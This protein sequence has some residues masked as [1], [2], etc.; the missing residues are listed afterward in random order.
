MLVGI[1]GSVSLLIQ[2]ASPYRINNL[3]EPKIDFT[4]PD[5]LYDSNY[6][7]LNAKQCSTTTVQCNAVLS[8]LN[9]NKVCLLN[10]S[11]LLYR[12]QHRFSISVR[13]AFA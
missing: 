2:Y 13:P 1:L 12:N 8:P 4:Q 3:I 10:Q 5:S 7:S 6:I 9:K 11:Y